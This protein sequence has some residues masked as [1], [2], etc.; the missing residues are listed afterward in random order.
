MSTPSLAFFHL[1]GGWEWI[2]IAVIALL[3]FGKRLPDVA[4]GMGKSIVEFK[5]GIKG[6]TDEMH[7]VRDDIDSQVDAATNEP[8]QLEANAESTAV[9]S[10]RQHASA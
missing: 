9:D 8:A 4:R 2:V 5:K 6:M 3:L 10:E 1:P 7:S